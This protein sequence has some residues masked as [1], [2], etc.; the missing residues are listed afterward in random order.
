MASTRRSQSENSSVWESGVG[1]I[2]FLF[3]RLFTASILSLYTGKEKRWWMLRSMV[4]PLFGTLFGRL[5]M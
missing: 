3:F 2:F 5:E 4:C 1:A